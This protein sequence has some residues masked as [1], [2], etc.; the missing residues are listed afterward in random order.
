MDSNSEHINEW[1]SKYMVLAVTGTRS[2]NVSNKIR[3]HLERFLNFVLNSYGH[4]RIE[5]LVRRDVQSWRDFILA[6]GLSPCNR[7]QSP[8]LSIG[9]HY[10]GSQL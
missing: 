3:L 9:F 7:Q 8:C 10:M 4:D 1:I 6:Q 2:N 5:T